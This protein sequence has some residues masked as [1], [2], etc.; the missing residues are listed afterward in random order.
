MLKVA[1]IV[2]QA[3]GDRAIGVEFISASYRIAQKVAGEIHRRVAAHIT[4]AK[5]VAAEHQAAYAHHRFGV[6]RYGRVAR[7]FETVRSTKLGG[8]AY[9]RRTGWNGQRRA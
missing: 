9:I 7:E 5:I 6:S 8:I 2:L 1:R 4:L 3:P